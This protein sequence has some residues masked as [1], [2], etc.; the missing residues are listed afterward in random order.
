MTIEEARP[1]E[2]VTLVVRVER[3]GP[4]PAKGRPWR[5]FVSDGVS[6][7]QL[8]FFHAH[9]DWI[10][11]QLPAGARRLISGRLELFDGMAQ[12]V[13]PDHIGPE[14]SDPPPDFEPVY[15]L[16]G[17]L[18]QKVMAKAVAAALDRVPPLPEWIDAALLAQKGWPDWPAALGAAHAPAS[19]DDL[20][21]DA[22]ARAR[23]AYDELLAHQMTLALVR[24]DR[25]RVKFAIGL[26]YQTPVPVTNAHGEVRVILHWAP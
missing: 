7:L 6:D 5:V 23:L 4:P 18:T 26:I 13:H 14:A 2:I 20:S 17:S 11:K 15:P 21:P 12:M 25:R 10:E 19:F 9:R 22:P 1:P 8:V 16:A 3:V 24:R